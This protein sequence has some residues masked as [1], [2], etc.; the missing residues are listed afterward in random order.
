MDDL[1]PPFRRATPQDAAALADLVDF[2]GEG[3]P[4]Y[5]WARMA[6]EGETPAEVGRRRAEREE[7]AFSYRNAV[8]TDLGSGPVAALIGYALPDRPE[9]IPDDFPLMFIPLQEL[10][11][12][13]C[14]TWYV[15]VLAAYP[16]HRRQGH[17]TRLLAIAERLA[18]EAGAKCVSIIVAD[19]NSPARRLYERRGFR[20]V[21]TRPM[22]KE[23]WQHP[24]RDWMLLLPEP[25]G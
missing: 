2:A 17:G 4:S 20:T 24:G 25:A 6:Q 21:A 3:L 19:T 23:G 1:P 12:M 5:V 7:G 15:N 9:P 22:V 16:E 11:N 18:A 10:E 8:V 13:A 14:G